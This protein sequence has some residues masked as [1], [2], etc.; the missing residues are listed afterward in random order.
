MRLLVIFCC[1]QGVVSGRVGSAGGPLS[2]RLAALSG[3]SGAVSAGRAAGRAQSVHHGSAARDPAAGAP[4]RPGG[5]ECTD[6]MAWG[7]LEEGYKVTCP[8]CVRSPVNFG[9]VLVRMSSTH[10][11]VRVESSRLVA[12]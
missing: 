1:R 11:T 9:G 6:R 10:F 3:A 5:R 4:H 7:G 8:C 2:V 12:F